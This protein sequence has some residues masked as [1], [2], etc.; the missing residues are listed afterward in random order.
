LTLELPYLLQNGFDIDLT[1]YNFVPFRQIQRLFR[2]LGT[3][4]TNLNLWGNILVFAP[5]GFTVP[6]LKAYKAPF[7]AGALWTCA[8][9]VCIELTQL[10]TPRTTDIDD[11]ILNTLGGM[12]GA[13]IYLLFKKCFPNADKKIKQKI[14]VK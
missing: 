6:L 3:A 10:L 2:S 8:T 9:S 13:L 14:M 1:D 5:I 4:H 12:L 7:L 11:V